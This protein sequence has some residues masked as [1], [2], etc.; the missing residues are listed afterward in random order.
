MVT[1]TKRGALALTAVVAAAVTIGVP[2]DAT[3]APAIRNGEPTARELQVRI[4]TEQ[5][6]RL[7]AE[8]AY[9]KAHCH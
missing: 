8:V 1:L 5:V 2:A 7:Q 9:L 4:L 6:H 3:R